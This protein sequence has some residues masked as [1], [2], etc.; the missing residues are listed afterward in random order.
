MVSVNQTRE[1][2]DPAVDVACEV[3]NERDRQDAKWGEQNHPDGTAPTDQRLRD[4]DDAI[5]STDREAGHGT[6]TWRH[7]LD[8][9]VREAFAESDP[10]K[11]R[12]ELIQIAAVAQQWVEAIDRRSGSSGC[13]PAY[14]DRRQPVVIDPVGALAALPV[15]DVVS[16]EWPDEPTKCTMRQ[17]P[18]PAVWWYE[19]PQCG[20]TRFACEP[21]RAGQHAWLTERL[22]PGQSVTCTPCGG[23]IPFPIPWRPL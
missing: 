11:L 2:M 14:P 7:I 23:P 15:L 8:E 16:I 22:K 6:V 17:C 13:P 19:C 10:D 3:L 4:R 12:T 18:R 20:C 5:A 1:P 9:E 21:H